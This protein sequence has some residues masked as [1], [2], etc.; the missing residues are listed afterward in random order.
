MFDIQHLVRL[1][2]SHSERQRAGART[3]VGPVTRVSGSLAAGDERQAGP[4]PLPQA[5]RGPSLL[6]GDDTDDAHPQRRTPGR[7]RAPIPTHDAADSVRRP[8]A[9]E[10][11]RAGQ[12]VEAVDVSGAG[13]LLAR[14][15]GTALPRHAPV[16]VASAPLSVAQRTDAGESADALRHSLERSGLFYEA[17]LARWAQGRY[18]FSALA[19]EPQATWP[20]GTLGDDALALLASQLD[21]LECNAIGWHGEFRPQVPLHIQFVVAQ[22][23]L[24]Q[25]ADHCLP[26]EPA[27]TAS[28][29]VE[30]AG[31]GRV[32]TQI[33]VTRDEVTYTV[34]DEGHTGSPAIHAASALYEAALAR[35]Q[36][37]ARPG[38]LSVERD[39]APA[40]T[41]RGREG[42][43]PRR[44]RALSIRGGP[45]ADIAIRSR[46]AGLYVHESPGLLALLL[47]LDLDPSVPPELYLAIAE[48]AACLLDGNVADHARS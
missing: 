20:A 25:G 21:A 30:L 34:A 43:H 23:F 40:G 47:H 4:T 35:H 22:P 26:P 16:V 32:C 31:M 13:R 15:I 24:Q 41:P 37:H 8:V 46:A 44:T 45:V 3:V 10:H 14:L 48:W 39:A 28:V 19:L 33:A 17:H 18:P 9:R 38:R 7:G 1:I 27:A 12:E 36:L 5:W 11:D 29:E 6:D 2:E 42:A